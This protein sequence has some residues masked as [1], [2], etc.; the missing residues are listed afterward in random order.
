[1]AT[2]PRDLT[3]PEFQAQKTDE[4]L[5][6]SIR[7]G[8]GQMPA[9]GGLM[10]NEDIADVIAF[11][12]T[13]VPPGTVPAQNGSP[14]ASPVAPSAPTLPAPVVVPLAPQGTASKAAELAPPADVAV[15]VQV[16]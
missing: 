16:R 7:L 3:R 1:L 12:R 5:R 6:Q 11:V 13:L 15:G 14:A 9:F 10:A 4:Q 2:P 8:K